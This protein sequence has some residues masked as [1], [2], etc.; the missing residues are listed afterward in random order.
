VKARVTERNETNEAI[1]SLWQR[2]S[3][4]L[5]RAGFSAEVLSIFASLLV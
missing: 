2:I 5:S 3:I 1:E 4:E